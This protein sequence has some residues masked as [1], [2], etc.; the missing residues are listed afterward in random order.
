MNTKGNSTLSGKQSKYVD[1]MS[2]R[3]SGKHRSK[4]GSTSI[5]QRSG[6]SRPKFKPKGSTGKGTSPRA[7]GPKTLKK[8]Q[9]QA[10]KDLQLEVRLRRVADQITEEYPGDDV[11]PAARFRKSGLKLKSS[12]QRQESSE[13]GGAAE[14]AGARAG[15]RVRAKKGSAALGMGQHH[16]EHSAVPEAAE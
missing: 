2:K 13:D 15:I 7:S 3:S 8:A 9:V 12:K 11:S 14:L 4:A 1:A 16:P 5:D 6:G 10:S